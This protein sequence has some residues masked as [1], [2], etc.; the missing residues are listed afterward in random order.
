VK[1]ELQREQ[2]VNTR[3]QRMTYGLAENSQPD[4]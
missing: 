2:A 1:P 3:R 4:Y